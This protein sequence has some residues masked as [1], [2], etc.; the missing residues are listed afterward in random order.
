MLFIVVFLA[1]FVVF[2]AF[3]Y[4][5]GPILERLL[6]HAAHRTAAF[7]YHDYLPVLVVLA[8]G[9]AATA[10]AGDAFMDI[11]ERVHQ[12]SAR[13]TAFDSEVHAWARTAYTNGSTIFFVTMTDIGDPV[14]LGIIV[15]ITSIF[16][17]MRKRWKWLAYL[18][19]TSGVGGLLNLELKAWFA[20][21]RPDLAEALRSAHGYS[22]PSGHAM[23][24]TIVLGSVAYIVF[25]VLTDWRLRATALALACSMIIAIAASRVYL[26]VHWISDVAGGIAAGAI[27]L[28][29]TT[30][31]YETFRRI[32]RVRGIRASRAA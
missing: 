32:R 14:G 4:A 6:A 13:L 15:F 22:F 12:N 27:W 11:A 3:F 28:V 17:A 5:V 1:L 26:G 9:I 21:A 19:F 25:R 31:A 30:V 10:A 7:R 29:T 18:L 16:L 2:W 24:S 8:V 23:G 20:R